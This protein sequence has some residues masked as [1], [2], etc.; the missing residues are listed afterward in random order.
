MVIYMGIPFKVKIAW[1][2]MIALKDAT[3]SLQN[4]IP[5]TL[6]TSFVGKALF[7]VPTGNKQ[8]WIFK[9]TGGNKIVLSYRLQDYNELVSIIAMKANLPMDE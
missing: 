1:E 4:T 9:L 3:F 7:I 5:Q 2:N 6:L 8:R